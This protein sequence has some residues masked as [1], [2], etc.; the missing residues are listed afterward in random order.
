MTQVETITGELQAL[1]NGAERA[2]GLTA[3][4]DNQAQEIALKAAGAGFAAVAA[5]MTRVRAAIGDIRGGLSGLGTAIDE[6]SKATAAVPR[7]ATPQDTVAALAPVQ[8]GI[9]G[10]RE[11]SA[12][13]ITQIGTVQQLVT[14]VLHGGQ[15]GPLLQAL[16]GIKQVLA[17]LAQRASAAEQAVEAAIA[18]ARRLGSAGN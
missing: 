5:G 13:T 12:A 10:A 4:A 1:A 3:A 17:L 18:E 16:D 7:E 9:I 8:Q 14:T 6:A 11:A 15:P 2:Q